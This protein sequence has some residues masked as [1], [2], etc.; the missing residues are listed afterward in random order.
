[1]QLYATLTHAG[2][3]RRLKRLGQEALRVYPVEAARIV[4][5]IHEENTTFRVETPEGDVEL[6]LTRAH[7][8]DEDEDE[9]RRRARRRNGT[10]AQGG[11]TS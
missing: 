4:P 3:V 9:K 2:Q 8:T 6:V 10:R 11:L 1:M 5:L 7:T